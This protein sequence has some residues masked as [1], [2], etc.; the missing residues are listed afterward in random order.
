MDCSC[1]KTVGCYVLLIETCLN[2][3]SRSVCEGQSN[4]TFSAG[5][6]FVQTADYASGQYASFPTPRTCG[7]H[8]VSITFNRSFLFCVK[9]NHC[10]RYSSRY[11]QKSESASVRC[12]LAEGRKKVA[13]AQTL[14]FRKRWQDLTQIIVFIFSLAIILNNPICF[15]ALS[16]TLGW[17][18]KATARRM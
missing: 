6:E 1:P 13:R 5:I 15:N 11:W 2:L 12:G 7:N 17:Q 10:P 9:A 14:Q 18:A 8:D 4:D 16:W 3:I